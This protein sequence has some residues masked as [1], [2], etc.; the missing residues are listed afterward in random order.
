MN[1]LRTWFALSGLVAV[2]ACHRTPDAVERA[3]ARDVSTEFAGARAICAA[4]SPGS[5]AVDRALALGR[6]H[7]TKAPDSVD[8][9]LT[10]GADWVRK[11]RETFDPGFYVNATA[12][13]DAALSLS[14]ENTMA[15]NLRAFSQLNDHR[16]G[17][18]RDTASSVL[19]RDGANVTAWGTLSDAELELGNVGEAERAG[20]RMLDLKPSLSSY[21]RAAYLRWLHGDS[22]AAKR[23]GEAAVRAGL[24][25]PDREPLAW[26]L[27]QVALVFWNEGDRAGAAAGF[28]LALQNVPDYAPANVGKARV[29]MAEGRYAEAAVALEKAHAKAPLVET[30]WLLGDARRLA[31]D[32][33]RAEATYAEVARD[34][35]LHDRRTL[36]LFFATRKT[37]L[38]EAVALA[39]AEF[40]ERPGLY[41]KDALAWA[42]YRIGNL[43]EAR[44][45][46]D[47]AIAFGTPDARLYFHAGA[48]RLAQGDPSGRALVR[49]AL[50]MNPAFDIVEAEEARQLVT[51]GA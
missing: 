4:T 30:A 1:A 9:W 46:A 12:C 11:A 6:D 32:S 36:A 43:D 51:T 19:A 26:A 21:A 8:V 33:T 2:T 27:V 3:P 45:L 41:S 16:F 38:P 18:A 13:A 15:E 48:I 28:E 47:Q 42:L 50:T 31:G 7:A 17:A 22:S 29:A 39:R 23:L 35:R 37:N 34:G 49:R 5:S 10:L 24:E 25:S 44:L 40:G 20:Q 14:P